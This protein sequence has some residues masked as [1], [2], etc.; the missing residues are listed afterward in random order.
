MKR[1]YQ[2]M[3]NFQH[4]DKADQFRLSQIKEQYEKIIDQLKKDNATLTTDNAE[5]TE[6]VRSLKS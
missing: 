3:S 2:S 6:E 4:N 5:K 1:N